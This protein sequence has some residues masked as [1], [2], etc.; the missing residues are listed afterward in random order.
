[1]G[2]DGGFI[3]E[4]EE[5]M[6]NVCGV[7]A[8]DYYIVEQAEDPV[9]RDYHL[10]NCCHFNNPS[11]SCYA[12][13]PHI[14]VSQRR[15]QQ[16]MAAFVTV[17]DKVKN[18]PKHFP[19][20]IRHG[21]VKK[22]VFGQDSQQQEERDP[23]WTERPVI[24]YSAPQPLHY[25]SMLVSLS[26]EGDAALAALLFSHL[27][28]EMALHVGIGMIRALAALHRADFIHRLVTPYSFSMPAAPLTMES[29]KTLVITDLSLAMPWPPSG[30]LRKSIPFVGTKR[31]SS[32]KVHQG[33]EQGPSDDIIS[34]IY[35]VAEMMSA[36]LPWRSLK[37]MLKIAESKA[38]F[39]QKNEFKRLPRE[40]RRL[41]KDLILMPSASRIDHKDIL[42][43]FT[44]ALQRKDPENS[45]EWPVWAS[46]PPDE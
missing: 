43:R 26:P 36:R 31:Y 34:V 38:E 44:Q 15:A 35:C 20:L 1:M 5:T 9:T 8:S 33:F 25:L 40:L 24:L 46:T 23:I 39:Y 14:K 28:P 45:F 7:L 10:Y 19:K 16:S 29:M 32:L 30:Q 21:F 11:L 17:L 13:I 27:P 4:V 3:G 42:A 12:I 18:R 22:L 6:E 2:D 41:Y 37:D